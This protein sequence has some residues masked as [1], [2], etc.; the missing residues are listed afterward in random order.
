MALS[1]GGH[2]D[3]VISD[4]GSNENEDAKIIAQREGLLGPH[5]AHQEKNLR[6]VLVANAEGDLRK[7]ASGHTHVFVR[8]W[9]RLISTRHWKC[10]GAFITTVPKD[11]NRKFTKTTWARSQRSV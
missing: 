10:G 4:Y 3:L 8:C 1:D 6:Q 11:H 9:Q 2:P 7:V 5:Q